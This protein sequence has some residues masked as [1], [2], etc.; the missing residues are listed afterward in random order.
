MKLNSPHNTE[1]CIITHY[2]ALYFANLLQFC[3]KIQYQKSKT[4][5]FTGLFDNCSNT[6]RTY[7]TSTLTVVPKIIFFLK[8]LFYKAFHD[9]Y[10]V[11]LYNFYRVVNFL[12]SKQDH[13]LLLLLQTTLFSSN[14]LRLFIIP[15]FVSGTFSHI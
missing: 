6:S 12:R 4:L 3:C 1:L 10:F 2:S 9:T 14:L 5:D 13:V 11:F 7:C 15:A 8:C